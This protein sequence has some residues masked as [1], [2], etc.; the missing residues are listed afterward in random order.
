MKNLLFG[1][2]MGLTSICHSQ[3]NGNVIHI[4]GCNAEYMPTSFTSG[5]SVYFDG[6][7]YNV[8]CEGIWDG[9]FPYNGQLGVLLS[10]SLDCESSTFFIYDFDYGCIGWSH[11]GIYSWKAFPVLSTSI[12][13]VQ[14]FEFKMFPNP[15]NDILTIQIGGRSKLDIFSTSGQLIMTMMV[16][17]GSNSVDLSDI[18]AGVYVVKINNVSKQL[19]RL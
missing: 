7:S 4:N 5:D 6:E 11:Q 18:L 3:W 17:Y 16:N 9:T 15:A 14:N 12:N 8:S 10:G 1:L 13:E 2:C 19:I